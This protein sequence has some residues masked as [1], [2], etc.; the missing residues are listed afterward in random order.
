MAINPSEYSRVLRQATLFALRG[1]TVA[2]KFLLTLYTTRYLGLADLGIYGLLIGATTIVP[3]I[4]GLGLTDWITRKIVNAPVAEAVPLIATRLGASAGVHLIVQPII[5]GLNVALGS[6]IPP[7]LAVLGGLILALDHLANEASD[8]LVARAR[9]YSSALLNFL[10]AGLW[11]ALVIA[12][13]LAFPATR[14]LQFLL[15]G[16][17]VALVVVWAVLA[18]L[19]LAGGRW[20]H[21]RFRWRLLRLGVAEGFS[22]YVK[23]VSNAVG[24]FVDRFV[25]SIF[26]GLELTGV[27][28]LFWSVA[29]V[30]HSLTVFGVVQPDIARLVMAG[31]GGDARTFRALERRLQIETA[32]WA[33]VLSF[34]A[35]AVLPFLLPFLARPLLQASLPIFW[36]VMA[37]TLLRIG[38]D[39]YGFVLF[40]LQRDRVIATLA[41]GAAL[42][43]ALLN[44]ALTPWAGL[45]GAAAAFV[46]T[47]GGLFALRYYFSRRD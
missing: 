41:I 15:L 45:Y 25:I 34:C 16:W 47:S 31:Q 39:G 29:N 40:A 14:T 19:A 12:V 33:V 46:V 8:M 11:P 3:A 5:L 43:S 27:Y 37:A 1:G 28:T 23:D 9:V 20:R 44:L 4:V 32:G 17:V 2:A 42:A 10:R 7:M 6:P 21:L 13:G 35:S 30:V 22:F 36:I 18:A 24:S 26:L 38:A